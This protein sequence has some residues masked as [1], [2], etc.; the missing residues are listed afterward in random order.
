[1]EK[2][3]QN[4]QKDPPA[5]ELLFPTF[6]FPV[7]STPYTHKTSVAYSVKRDSKLFT[8]SNFVPL[9][10]ILLLLLFFFCPP[11]LIFTVP[12]LVLSLRVSSMSL[13]DQRW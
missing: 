10:A 3:K 8:P 9:S 11:S 1:M 7:Q 13:C 4:K 12:A 2:E 6:V 5:Y